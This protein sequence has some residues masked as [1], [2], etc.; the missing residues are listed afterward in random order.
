MKQLHTRHL[1]SPGNSCHK[2]AIS[3]LWQ[4]HH[5]LVDTV[6]KRCVWTC[7]DRLWL[8]SQQLLQYSLTVY[9][10][11]HIIIILCATHL[12]D[13]LH[14]SSYHHHSLCYSSHWL[15]TSII[16]SIS[17]LPISAHASIKQRLYTY[18]YYLLVTFYAQISGI[19]SLAA[20]QARPIGLWAQPTRP[21]RLF[22]FRAQPG[23]CRPLLQKAKKKEKAQHINVMPLT[24]VWQINN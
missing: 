17:S 2:L 5:C 22:N 18:T 15:S 4:C 16:I 19:I 12:T 3:K 7:V 20:H 23:P 8:K 1:F 6:G 21:F 10:N 13:C 9:I 11:H 14:Q 24:I